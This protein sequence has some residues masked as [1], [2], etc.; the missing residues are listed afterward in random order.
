MNFKI[1]YINRLKIF[2]TI[3]LLILISAFAYFFQDVFKYF[4]NISIDARSYLSV[5][6]G[7]FSSRFEPADSDIVIVKGLV[8]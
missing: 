6:G 8:D 1:E 7:L 3:L 2:I 5:D 4:E